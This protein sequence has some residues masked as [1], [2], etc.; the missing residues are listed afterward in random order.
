MDVVT[1]E[2]V[3]DEW[4]NQIDNITLN[5]WKAYEQLSVEKQKFKDDTAVNLS[6]T[7]GVNNPV[8]KTIRARIDVL[9]EDRRT[10]AAKCIASYPTSIVRIP[11]SGAFGDL[12]EG[13]SL[14]L[15]R[16]N[17]K[18]TPDST[19]GELMQFTHAIDPASPFQASLWQCR[20]WW[21]RGGWLP[22]C[23]E[24]NTVLFLLVDTDFGASEVTEAWL[25]AT[26]Q[27][28]AAEGRNSGGQASPVDIS[29]IDPTDVTDRVSGTLA[30]IEF[31][32]KQEAAGKRSGTAKVPPATRP[33]LGLG[34]PLVGGSLEK[35]AGAFGQDQISNK[36]RWASPEYTGG[37]E[38]LNALAE[39][40]AAILAAE[41]KNSS[42]AAI[43]A[44]IAAPSKARPQRCKVTERVYQ[45]PRPGQVCVRV[46]MDDK[47][48][49]RVEPYAESFETCFGPIM[50]NESPIAYEERYVTDGVYTRQWNSLARIQLPPLA[51]QSKFEAPLTAAVD[52]QTRE[53]V[54]DAR[55]V[56]DVVLSHGPA[57][58]TAL[59]VLQSQERL[60]STVLSELA[61]TAE[62]PNVARALTAVSESAVFEIAEETAQIG[63]DSIELRMDAMRAMQLLDKS[64]DG[65]TDYDTD[66]PAFARLLEPPA[67][68]NFTVW[69][70][71][72]YGTFRTLSGVATQNTPASF[73]SL[74]RDAR[75]ELGELLLRGPIVPSF[76]VAARFVAIGTNEAA[77]EK[78]DEEVAA[79]EVDEEAMDVDQG[80]VL[81]LED[82][83]K[84]TAAATGEFI[85]PDFPSV[86]D[87]VMQERNESEQME[88]VYP[89]RRED[90]P[91]PGGARQPVPA[92]KRKQGPL[93]V[94]EGPEAKRRKQDGGGM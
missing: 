62:T 53:S 9:K 4:L 34:S 91:S 44:V 23:V 38:I 33:K 16:G 35:I 39:S 12:P 30:S 85:Y 55:M 65:K 78:D 18:L 72:S 84:A 81:N 46:R 73:L 27:E 69:E 68:A 49:D 19:P 1:G 41:R 32:R 10:W 8:C 3:P 5:I 50:Q 52:G 56:D 59:K 66:P 28:I 25:M 87:V 14:S 79:V 11:V 42:V 37:R 70:S 36:I 43:T 64:Y 90:I 2:D 67:A 76:A 51:Y 24:G 58:L 60:P 61:A 77:P 13:G 63:V 88:D 89:I 29:L 83:E 31:R 48:L 6:G 54:N 75:W 22:V 93:D 26:E 86:E 57:L 7:V 20:F 45:R 17:S 15:W 94:V 80:D 40:D 82:V 92:K 74:P 71:P 47:L 21:L